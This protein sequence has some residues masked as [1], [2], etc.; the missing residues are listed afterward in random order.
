MAKKRN[1]PKN[2]ELVALLA[3]SPG[4][5]ALLE[6]QKRELQEFD[7]PLPAKCEELLLLAAEGGLFDLPK[8][9]VAKLRL[10]FEDIVKEREPLQ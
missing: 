4:R 5:V 1:I 3:K 7:N 2:P 8:L 6:K 10:A 9:P